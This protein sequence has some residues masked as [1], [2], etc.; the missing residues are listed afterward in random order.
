M[1]CE[2]SNTEVKFVM[3]N[4]EAHVQV[5]VAILMLVFSC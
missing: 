1:L 4:K 5:S 2:Y 3:L